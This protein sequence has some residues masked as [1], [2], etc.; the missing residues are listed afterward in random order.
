MLVFGNESM[1]WCG[2]CIS[3]CMWTTLYLIYFKVLSKYTKRYA[4]FKKLHLMVDT[5]TLL[6]Y[7]WIQF[8][9]L[10]FWW[11]S[12][13]CKL[14]TIWQCI[15]WGDQFKYTQ[16]SD[17]KWGSSMCCWSAWQIILIVRTVATGNIDLYR[18]VTSLFNLSPPA[19]II[20]PSRKTTKLNK[21][22]QL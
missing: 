1:F 6:N 20:V 3:S 22:C 15:F 16:K 19:I 12:L 21:L 9:Y 10:S 2:L 4:I 5:Y 8:F 14:I 7:E 18:Q 13:P 17:K 11:K